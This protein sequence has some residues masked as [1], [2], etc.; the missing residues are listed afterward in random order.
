MLDGAWVDSGNC[1]SKQ[2]DKGS[3]SK[4][5]FLSSLLISPHQ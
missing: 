1:Q 5:E 4:M 3:N 2:P